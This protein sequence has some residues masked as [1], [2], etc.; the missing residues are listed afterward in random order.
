VV[1][2]ARDRT[3]WRVRERQKRCAQLSVARGRM[4]RERACISL[5]FRREEKG[6]CWALRCAGTHGVV[7]AS[8][9]RCCLVPWCVRTSGREGYEVL[10][11]SPLLEDTT[12]MPG[13]R[14][15]PEL[16]DVHA[17]L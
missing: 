7:E 10:L 8:E 2:A 3:K 11:S 13:R 4:G 6:I 14:G 16:S 1:P 9:M 17:L 15:A 5:L 12:E